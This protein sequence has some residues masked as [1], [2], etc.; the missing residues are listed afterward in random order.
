[1]QNKGA[2]SYGRNGEMDRSDMQSRAE[3]AAGDVFAPEAKIVVTGATGMV[4]SHLVAELL[5]R[6]C[7]QLVLPVRNPARAERLYATLEREGVVPS[8]GALRIVEA[9]LNN[10]LELAGL[11]EGTDTVFHCAARVSLDGGGAEEMIETN[12]EMTAHLVNAALTCGVRRFMH[13]SSIAALG[14]APD[15][16]L[17]DET[18]TLES[19]A[20]T[21]PYG[22]GKF[23]AEN[24]VWRGVTEGLRAVVVN[25]AVILGAGDWCTGS[26]AIVPVLA[27][28]SF[29]YPQGATGF[30]DVH[31]V[32]RALADLAGCGGAVGE[33]FIL[34]GGN[35]SYRELL[36]AGARA[37]GC[38]RPKMK[39]GPKLLAAAVK[40]ARIFGG[41]ALLSQELADILSRSCRYDGSKIGRYLP[42][43]VYTSPERSVARLVALYREDR[44]KR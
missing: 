42:S 44:K 34:C 22:I 25:P 33:R 30:V 37:S 41:R 15:G 9:A 7:S 39:A 40:T 18:A 2:A 38:R 1:M 14:T 20:G 43:F 3:D 28:G 29:F 21:S 23:F 19:L 36:E 5:R 35:L 17:T 31:D 24:E 26:S 27:G 32:A 6:G 12:V 4:G 13:V 11:L 8:P 16:G 10:P